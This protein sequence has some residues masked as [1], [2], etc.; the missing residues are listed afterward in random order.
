MFTRVEKPKSETR[1]VK[2]L[3]SCLKVWNVRGDDIESQCEREAE[4]HGI[5]VTPS[6]LALPGALEK[7]VAWLQ[8]SV[9][10]AGVV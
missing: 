10:D 9:D 8:I 7:Y 2:P 5:H 4:A 6:P 3:R 1:T